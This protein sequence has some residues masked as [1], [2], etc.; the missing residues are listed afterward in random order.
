MAPKPRL[1]GPAAQLAGCSITL[2]V[3]AAVTHG[4]LSTGA[5]GAGLG[6]FIEAIYFY[7]KGRPLGRTRDPETRA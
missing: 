1:G 4:W 6:M 3:L 7:R 2:L 5:L